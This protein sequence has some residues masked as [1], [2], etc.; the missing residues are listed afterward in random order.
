MR[1]Y[2]EVELNQMS[3]E[4]LGEI[5]QS[6]GAIEFALCGETGEDLIPFILVAQMNDEEFAALSFR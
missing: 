6:T 4:Q 1:V 5:A 2:T 3:D